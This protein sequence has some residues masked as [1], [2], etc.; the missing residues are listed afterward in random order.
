ML[1]KTEPLIMTTTTRIIALATAL[2]LIG[3]AQDN[4]DSSST[5]T[6]AEI[7]GNP[8]YPA[9]SYGGYREL[10]REVV[11]TEEQLVEDVKILHAM[12]IRLLRTY[13]T[14]QY[15]M[16]A[17]LLAAIDRVRAEDPTFEMYVMLGA[18]IEAEN[19]WSE[20]IWDPET[21]TWVEGSTPDHSKGNV[22]N[23]T[24]E[25]NAA[26]KLANQ[27]PDIVKAIAVGN[28]AMVQW[29]VAYFV[30][31]PVILKWV[32]HLQALKE[33]GEL[34]PEIWVTSSD[35]YESW[36]GGNPV[37]RSED[38]TA[39]MHAVDFLSVHTYPFH[40]SF[41]NPEYWGVLAD[42]EELSKTEMTEAVMRRAITYAQSQ[43][44]AVVDYATSLGISKPIHIGETGWATTDG[45]AY[46]IGGS[47]AAD[48]Y[49][50]KLFHDYLRDWTNEAGIS[51]FYFEAF[52]ER[53]KQADSPQGSENHFGLIRLNNEVKYA[54]WDEFDA[55]A[56]DGLTRDGQPLVK[57]FSG[58]ETA[59][60]TAA[61]VPPFKSQMAVRR[62]ASSNE[63]RSAG[64]PVTES[65]YIVSHESITPNN[66]DSATYPSAALKLTPWEG[67]AS[68]EQLPDTVISVLTREGDWWGVS[69]ELDAEVGED[70]SAFS[71]GSLN[72]ELRGDTGTTFSIGFQTGNFLRGDQVNNFASFG[73]EGDYQIQE[74]WQTFSFPIETING[75]ANLAD[76]TNVIALMSRTQDANKTI[77]LKNIYFSR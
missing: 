63:A 70:L 20:G 4:K 18:W 62:L 30:Y 11:P 69:L 53:W 77:Q 45:A 55:G 31:P 8:N 23:N 22:L 37:Y 41:Y 40:D 5:P 65:T 27:Y 14:S 17:R 71:V 54:L 52:D 24:A 10:T 61:M 39:L 1:E 68:I 9:M 46:G 73:P 25:I 43:Y 19:S 15:P 2:L 59:L 72:L 56:F 32:N 76:V 21:N 6:A 29:A 7:F 48:E 60:L 36:G 34:D 50:Q 26:V 51:L 38:L 64:E 16:A 13:N 47:K 35:N 75:G 58:D 67:T 33:S 74:N 3:C 12:G 66:S 28:E 57:S 49:K 42:E 44:N